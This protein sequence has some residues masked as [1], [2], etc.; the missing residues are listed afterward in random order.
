MPTGVAVDEIS[1][2]RAVAGADAD[3]LEAGLNSDQADA[4]TVAL[5]QYLL[6]SINEARA[7]LLGAFDQISTQ[8]ILDSWASVASK[9]AAA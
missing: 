6:G 8:R 2:R 3:L 9:V 5:R 7:T 4:M 1:A